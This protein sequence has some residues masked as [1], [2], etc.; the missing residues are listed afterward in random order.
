MTIF[1]IQKIDIAKLNLDTVYKSINYT[2]P[3]LTAI[4]KATIAVA[5]SKFIDAKSASGSDKISQAKMSVVISQ[6]MVPQFI[7]RQISF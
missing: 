6:L 4:Q 1:Y 3:V 5:I 7:I 2:G